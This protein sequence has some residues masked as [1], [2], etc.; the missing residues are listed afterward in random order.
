MIFAISVAS[1]SL[2]LHAKSKEDVVVMKN[3]DKFTGE[4]K[5]LENGVLYFK[6]DYM[7]D[8]VQLDWARVDR[9]ESQDHFNVYLISGKRL[10]GT[11]EAE[12][13]DQ[14]AKGGFAVQA[15]G[16]DTRA[17]RSEVVSM[18]PVEDS[19]W[20]QLKGSIDYGFAFTGGSDTTQSSLSAQVVYQT[21]KWAAQLSGSS[22]VNRQSGAK[23]SGRNTLDFLYVKYVTQHWFAG[24]TAGLLNS[25]QQDLTLRAT[26]GGVFGRD[27]L[28]SGTASLWVLGGVVFSRE[29]YSTSGEQPGKNE[30]ESQFQMLFS[31]YVFRRMQFNLQAAAYPNLTTL[32]RLRLTLESNLKLELVKNLYWKLSLYENHDNRPPVTAPKNDFGTSTSIGWKF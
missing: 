16:A 31:K 8:S 23:S 24:T 29:Q 27:F 25:Q 28:Q 18:V 17:R 2:P 14:D 7:V 20:A 11:I 26:G 19:F 15:S 12:A 5:K 32:G 6:A 21:E 30:A 13:E 22:V 1:G 9:L 3:G 4:I 10:T